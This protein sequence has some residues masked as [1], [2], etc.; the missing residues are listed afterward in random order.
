MNKKIFLLFL[1][2]FFCLHF[3]EAKKKKRRRQNPNKSYIRKSKKKHKHSKNSRQ[4]LSPKQVFSSNI[5]EKS[6]GLKSD[7]LK[8]EVPTLVSPGV[9]AVDSGSSV[10][11][12]E[13][14]A[15]KKVKNQSNT[16]GF[17]NEDKKF[18]AAWAMVLDEKKEVPSDQKKI[19][20]TRVIV[21]SLK[22]FLLFNETQPKEALIKKI[23][24]NKGFNFIIEKIIAELDKDRNREHNFDT[25]SNSFSQDIIAVFYQNIS[26]F[27]EY[28]LPRDVDALF[29]NERLFS[30]LMKN[31]MY[32][33]PM[34]LGLIFIT[35][36]Y[37]KSNPDSFTDGH[38][39]KTFQD[40]AVLPT[41]I[42]EI[43]AIR[44]IPFPAIYDSVIS[45]LGKLGEGK[46]LKSDEKREIKEIMKLVLLPQGEEKNFLISIVSVLLFIYYI[47][48]FALKNST[49]FS[50]VKKNA[51]YNIMFDYLNESGIP[52]LEYP[53]GY[54]QK[55]KLLS[56]EDFFLK[57][58]SF[59]NKDNYL[60]LSPD[61][62]FP[63]L[64]DI[65]CVIKYKMK[66][67]KEDNNSSIKDLLSSFLQNVYKENEDKA[68]SDY[69]LLDVFFDQ[70]KDID[71]FKDTESC[72]EYI[73]CY[74]NI[75][76]NSFF[77]L[78][79]KRKSF[80]D[81][82][83]FPFIEPKARSNA[84]RYFSKESSSK[85]TGLEMTDADLRIFLNNQ[86]FYSWNDHAI[87]DKVKGYKDVMFINKGEYKSSLTSYEEGLTFLY[88]LAQINKNLF[89]T[90]EK[91][92]NF[93]QTSNEPTE[94]TV[95]NNQ[96]DEDDSLNKV[97]TQEDIRRNIEDDIK[98]AKKAKEDLYQKYYQLFK[99]KSFETWGGFLYFFK[100]INLSLFQLQYFY[101]QTKSQIIKDKLLLL[102]K[103]YT[104]CCL[105]AIENIKSFKVIKTNKT[106]LKAKNT[107]KGVGKTALVGAVP[108]F[109]YL[110]GGKKALAGSLGA[111]AIGLGASQVVNQGDNYWKRLQD[112]FS[113]KTDQNIYA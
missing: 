44:G 60:S 27:K 79:D 43:P 32:A 62:L 71:L 31:L 68:Y 8:E 52:L 61:F 7:T 111:A 19:I 50:P 90:E 96:N 98:N 107:L 5:S 97:I 6:S 64:R 93:P 66:N 21:Y 72:N 78:T 51:I 110:A 54:A 42:L 45:L 53:E 28:Y 48:F 38:H 20:A 69:S 83:F 91:I 57:G 58:K 12:S 34:N 80:F 99:E 102:G 74:D 94:E 4:S 95:Q 46:I 81:V 26:S 104:Q 56:K 59:F 77:S 55:V 92:K 11:S 105:E 16:V 76:S 109:V 1:L 49:T 3:V 47:E 13:K 70:Q 14:A 37:F 33:M 9:S 103:F 18:Q 10:N 112:Y 30:I 25:F 63:F 85:V 24:S 86:Y 84:I 67:Q 41:D 29:E 113:R 89:V 87:A 17:F 73:E 65:L 39:N 101:E 108:L 106:M 40:H 88:K 75:Y 2:S 15:R 82:F 22:Q 23:E 35:Y 36:P 100:N